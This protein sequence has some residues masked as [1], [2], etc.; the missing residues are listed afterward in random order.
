MTILLNIDKWP[1][2]ARL[3]SNKFNQRLRTT[4]TDYTRNT[5][6]TRYAERAKSALSPADRLDDAAD[7]KKAQ[8]ERA[9]RAA[10]S[11]AHDS[12]VA[13]RTTAKLVQAAALA[14]A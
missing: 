2:K 8:L 4:N 11:V 10:I 7:A 5:G 9:A 6:Y 3:C 14:A 13:D 1:E 12:R